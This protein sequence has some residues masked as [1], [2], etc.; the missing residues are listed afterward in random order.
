[1]AAYFGATP[2]PGRHRA[3]SAIASFRYSKWNKGDPSLVLFAR[4]LSRAGHPNPNGAVGKVW[5][6]LVA[7]GPIS[8]LSEEPVYLVSDRQVRLRRRKKLPF[9][10]V[11][12]TDGKGAGP[13][14]G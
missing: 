8:R 14:D 5:R 11:A 10:I 1:M 3:I 7:S 13:K 12:T 9:K 6:E 4:I 2:F